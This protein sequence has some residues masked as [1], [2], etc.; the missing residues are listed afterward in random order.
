MNQNIF[1]GSHI[2][3]SGP[4]YFKETVKTA[5][6]YGENTFM[7]YTGAPQNSKESLLKNAKLMKAS[8]LLKNQTLI[9]LRL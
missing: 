4:D 7:F 9:Y 2:G 5:I 6:E 3:M 8:S 1:I